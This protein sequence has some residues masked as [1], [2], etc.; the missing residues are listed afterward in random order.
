MTSG[1]SHAPAWFG[2]SAAESGCE[3]GELG[4]AGALVGMKTA[5]IVTLASTDATIAIG[6]CIKR[7]QGWRGWGRLDGCHV[8]LERSQWRAPRRDCALCLC[9]LEGVAALQPGEL[10]GF[11][12]RPTTR[13]L[14]TTQDQHL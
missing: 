1:F 14:G 10:L 11:M 8:R 6:D 4:N 12:R 13:R 7:L 5:A 2:L 9:L 3:Q